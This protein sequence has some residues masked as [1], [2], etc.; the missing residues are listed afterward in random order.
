MG[1]KQQKA[2]LSWLRL[3]IYYDRHE[4][5]LSR[6]YND[7]WLN[8][9]I[10]DNPKNKAYY[11]AVYKSTLGL[12]ELDEG[13]LDPAK[14]SLREIESL[15]P[16]YISTMKVNLEFIH[17][18]ISTMKDN[19]EFIHGRLGSE[20]FLAEGSFSKAEDICRKTVSLA[21][22]NFFPNR[23][24]EVFYNMPFLRDVLGRVY[25]KKGDLD[26]AIAEYERL[27]TFD[28]KVESRYL[29]HPTY[30]YQLAKLYEQKGLREKAK[31]QYERFLELWKDADPGL[32]EA[33]DA[34][35]RLAGLKAK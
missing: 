5:D 15:L 17:G 23:A 1:A 27:I 12:M 24:D 18:Y 6:K 35:T 22:P 8:S 21:A 29:I 2:S 34:R 4:F 31:S 3:W 20:I 19:L 28:P 33:E 26:K 10:E 30:H 13:K 16:Q 9:F 32:P 14:S 25:V 7:A 11:E